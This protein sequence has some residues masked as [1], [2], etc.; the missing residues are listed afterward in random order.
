MF[1]PSSYSLL[2]CP[3]KDSYMIV[4]VSI[5]QQVTSFQTT[6]QWATYL[7]TVGHVTSDS[8]WVTSLQTARQWVTSHQTA[9]QWSQHSR[10]W[11]AAVNSG[12]QKE[13]WASNLNYFSRDSFQHPS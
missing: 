4:A 7:Q 8:E 6:R 9:R 3:E 5:R 2:H 11:I 13:T 1:K 12:K 10:Q